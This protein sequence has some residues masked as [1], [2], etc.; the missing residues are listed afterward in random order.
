MVSI[1]DMIIN[2]PCIT[3]LSECVA[4]I[5]AWIPVL[6]RS[7]KIWNVNYWCLPDLFRISLFNSIFLPSSVFVGLDNATCVYNKKN[8]I[9]LYLDVHSIHILSSKCSSLCKIIIHDF[10]GNQKSQ[11]SNPIPL[12]TV[13]IHLQLGFFT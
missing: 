7:V 3:S 2:P 9:D 10:N 4:V 5:V 13:W 8:I 12:I 1:N 6:C 11:E